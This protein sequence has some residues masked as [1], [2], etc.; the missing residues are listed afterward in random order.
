MKIGDLVKN[1]YAGLGIIMEEE[2]NKRHNL[3]GYWVCYF[4][5]PGEWRWHSFDE[6]YDIE[7]LSE[8]R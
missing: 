1:S 3:A 8:N 2:T 7:V 5:E 4:N 6:R